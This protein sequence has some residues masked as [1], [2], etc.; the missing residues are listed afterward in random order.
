MCNLT[1]VNNSLEAK[2]LLADTAGQS[3]YARETSGE[4]PDNQISYVYA[5]INNIA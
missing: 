2:L 3:I 1:S 4:F 5:L